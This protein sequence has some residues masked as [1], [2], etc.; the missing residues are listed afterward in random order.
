MPTTLILVRHGQTAWN[1][2]E[3]FR[4]TMD[5][6][7][8]ETGL[9]QAERLAPYVA[10]VFHPVALYASPL[11]R[12]LQTA[13]PIARATGLEARPHAGL[14]DIDFGEFTGLTPV[15]AEE[16][17]PAVYQDWLHAP[18]RVRFP[19]GEALGDVRARVEA[20]VGQL[21]A[22]H[23]A[24]GV[25]LVTHQVVG[26]VAVCALLGI[27]TEFFWRLRLDNTSLCAFEVS[28]RGAVMFKFNET[29]YLE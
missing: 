9:A 5:I 29:S 6:P 17:F 26:R 27:G 10:R 13:A 2:V 22:Q 20:M 25:V 24:Q 15:E 21:I 23:P 11:Q 16:R 28:E 4:G 8:N 12:A 19:G 18:E 3:R 14:L 1:K 7:L